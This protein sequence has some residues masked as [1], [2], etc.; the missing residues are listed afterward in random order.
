M[1]GY[2]AIEEDD[3]CWQFE[4]GGQQYPEDR[5]VVKLNYV[6]Y[7]NG[8]DITVWGGKVTVVASSLSSVWSRKDT[9]QHSTAQHNTTHSLLMSVCNGTKI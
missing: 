3:E 7:R 9:A 5:L 6:P 2:F 1:L 4:T 8:T